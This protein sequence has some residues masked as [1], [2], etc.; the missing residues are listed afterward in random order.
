[1]QKATGR[2]IEMKDSRLRVLAAAGLSSRFASS[3]F[4]RICLI[5]TEN[6]YLNVG[7]SDVT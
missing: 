6:G 2:W 1:M 5:G 7:G 4:E 3:H